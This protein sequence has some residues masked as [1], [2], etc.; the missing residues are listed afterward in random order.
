MVVN[1]QFL[2]VEDHPRLISVSHL[3]GG[4]PSHLVSGYP[5]TLPPFFV[6]IQCCEIHTECSGGRGGRSDAHS[7][8]DVLTMS[9]C[10]RRGRV[11][12]C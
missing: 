2:A 9:R 11:A 10:C 3:Y 1:A 5:H 4:P 8:Y 7:V 12:L 6:H